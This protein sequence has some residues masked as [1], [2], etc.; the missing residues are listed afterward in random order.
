MANPSWF[1]E[2]AY[3]NS[4][5]YQLRASGATEYT[6]ITQVKSAIEAAG[7]STYA[8]FSAYSLA[9]RTSP[10]EYFNTNEYLA[11]KAVQLNTTQGVTT[12]TAERVALAFQ[13][14]G[15]TN[16][17]DH[18]AQWGWAEN[19]NPSNAFDVSAY[20]DLKA[21]ETGMTVD[22]VKAAFAAAGLDP[23]SHYLT[24]GVNEAGISVTPVP[25]AEQVPADSYS[26]NAGQIFT[27]TN[28]ADVVTGT[29]G[30]DL[31]VGEID[32]NANIESSLN[33]SDVIDGGDGYDTLRIGSNGDGDEMAMTASSIT[34]V[35]RLLIVD[36]DDDFDTL[37]LAGRNFDLVEFTA[38]TG[39]FSVTVND[40]AIGTAFFLNGHEAGL[41]VNFDGATGSTDSADLE[42]DADV[43]LNTIDFSGI[44]M[45]NLTVS[46][47]SVIGTL[48]NTASDVAE[49]VITGAGSLEI[50]SALEAG[51]V[52]VDASANTGGVTL[53]LSMATDDVTVLGSSGDDSLTFGAG[54]DL[55]VDAGAGDDVVDLGGDLANAT[56]VDG[57]DG[58]D[59]IGLTVAELTA[60]TAD[61][62]AA[63]DN[64]EILRVSDALG[65][66]TIDMDNVNNYNNIVF[67]A[68][69]SS[70]AAVIDNV[71]NGATIT[72]LADAAATTNNLTVGAAT[73]FTLVLSG[74]G[75][76]TQDYGIVT[77]TTA[78]TLTI[79]SNAG[80]TA[81]ANVIDIAANPALVTLTLSGDADL[82]LAG[83]ALD[84]TAL[85]TVDAS[86]M[87]GAVTVTVDTGVT[88][89]G[90]TITGGSGGDV[91]TGGDSA[92]T[93]IGG[94]GDD[95][96]AGGDGADTL[97][98]GAGDDTFAFNFVTES[99]GVNQDT[100]T[101]FVSGEDVLD[102]NAI[103][104]G[105]GQYLGEANGYGAVLT[106]LTAT[107]GDAVLDATT[108]T[109][110]VDIDGS[111]TLDDADMAIVL[112]GVTDLA[113]TDFAF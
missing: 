67:A 87:T 4:K 43:S 49:L 70:A 80:D 66:A 36:G 107:V 38:P 72:Y 102:F 85:E 16:A 28:G 40:A 21:A 112:T 71:S 86:A 81:T 53:D 91:L 50:T 60:I 108:S 20:F 104:G 57:G 18:F 76:A 24:Y 62:A 6:T 22:Q 29:T 55:D 65:T 73:D 44:E 47:D 10:N 8:H 100:I 3:L 31:I 51:T 25:T 27:L 69:I 74:D 54:Q 83:I 34:N 101:D 78:E 103:T 17:Y 109:L 32:E 97:T 2:Y 106:S 63:L 11:A 95:T 35:E 82:D 37:E 64:F 89:M 88:D 105:V 92:D 52:S 56:N 79:V 58:D 14:A 13:N 19:V 99:Q 9:E 1:D 46:G 41:T 26:P 59:Q 12:W 68:G 93:V 84:N 42:I 45:L 23:I 96:I 7:W 94:E 110:Y 111:G 77:S 5:L 33:A 61:Q 39:G 48:T 30:D 113:A 90:V 15:Y 75:V 98:G